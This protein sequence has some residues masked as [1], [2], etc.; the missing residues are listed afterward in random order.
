MAVGAAC[1]EVP[2]DLVD[3]GQYGALLDR[4]PRFR[5]QGGARWE[6]G[7]P[8]KQTGFRPGPQRIGL[9]ARH[10]STGNVTV[11]LWGGSPS[12][13]A[14]FT[15][16]CE[17]EPAEVRFFSAARRGYS[18]T[19]FRI[20]VAG[21]DPVA[22]AVIEQRL[23]LHRVAVPA[24]ACLPPTQSFMARLE[25]DAND[26]RL[27][28]GVPVVRRRSKR[29]RPPIILISIDTLRADYWDHDR[30][31]PAV[32]DAFRKSAIRFERAFSASPTTHPSHRVMLSGHSLERTLLISA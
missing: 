8:I 31:R 17:G 21:G 13:G 4:T 5:S 15:F 29:S 3:V 20:T 25:I 7:R 19:G 22:I 9:R 1:V 10:E 28:I 30:A 27:M 12:A 2:P 23:Q 32:L 11:T 16:S 24:G 6:I 14:T 26:P 18:G